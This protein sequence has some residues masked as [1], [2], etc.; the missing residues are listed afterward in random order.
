VWSAFAVGRLVADYDYPVA[1]P[2]MAAMSLFAIPLP[3]G[4]NIWRARARFESVPA[5]EGAE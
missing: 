5:G 1:L 2:S 3:V 4:L